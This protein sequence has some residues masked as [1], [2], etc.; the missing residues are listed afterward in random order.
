MFVVSGGS[1]NTS[2]QR[3]NGLR[4]FA[5]LAHDPLGDRRR[6]KVQGK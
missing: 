6:V 3:A 4:P 1:A 2:F 5:R